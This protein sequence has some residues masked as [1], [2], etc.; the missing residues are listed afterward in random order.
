MDAK[1]W[2]AGIAAGLAPIA[3]VAAMWPSFEPFL[4]W[5]VKVSL[6]ILDRPTVQAVLASMALG[7]LLAGWLPHFAPDKWEAGRTKAVTRFV[8][9][10][11]TF[12]GC[13]VLLH[14]QT[15]QEQAYALFYC[16]LSSVASAQAWTTASGLLYRMKDKPESLKP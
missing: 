6:L 12:A 14:P 16:G 15:L 5:F 4:D 1:K 8:S 3:V 7:V 10:V 9:F 2:W 13:Y 11:L